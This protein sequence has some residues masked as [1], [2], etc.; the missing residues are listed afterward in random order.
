MTRDRGQHVCGQCS[1]GAGESGN[2]HGPTLA[3]N[4]LGSFLRY[5]LW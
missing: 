4:L 2:A 1:L 3:S 5:N